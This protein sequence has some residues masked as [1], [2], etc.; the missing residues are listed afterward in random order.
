MNW[1]L[2]FYLPNVSTMPI[3]FILPHGSNWLL[4]IAYEWGGIIFRT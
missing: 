1:Y 3:N 2:H 4:T